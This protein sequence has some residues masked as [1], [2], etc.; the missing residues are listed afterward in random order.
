MKS[1]AAKRESAANRRQLRAEL[2]DPAPVMEAAAAFIAVRPRSV[3]ETRRRLVRNGYPE[4]LVE[5]VMVEL[6]AVGYLDDEAFAKAWV[7]SRDRARPRGESALRREL[8][9]K[10]VPR[11]V[12]DVVLAERGELDT[13]TELSAAR[14]LL[15]R[16][17]PSLEREADPRKRRQKAFALLARNGFDS[18]VARQ[19]SASLTHT[20]DG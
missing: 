4:R 20:N 16:K 9:L 10:G 6:L 1:V 13:D 18:D 17:R 8:T 15:E 3:V 19:V 14:A 11:I 2:L 5:D 12:V 7:E